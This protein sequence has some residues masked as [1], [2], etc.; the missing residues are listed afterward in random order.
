MF[1]SSVCQVHEISF[2]PLALGKIAPEASHEE[3]KVPGLVQ[4]SIGKFFSI[5]KIQNLIIGA[6]WR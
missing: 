3:G 1:H 4:V 2:C 5:W 6:G